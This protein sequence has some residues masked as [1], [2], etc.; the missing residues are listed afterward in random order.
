ME[1]NLVYEFF[2][3]ILGDHGLGWV[4]KIISFVIVTFLTAVINRITTYFIDFLKKARE[5]RK[6]SKKLQDLN[7]FFSNTDISIHRKFF[8]ETKGQNLPPS[9]ELEPIRIE[10]LVFKE[11]LID[12]LLNQYLLVK[13]IKDKYFLVLAGSGMGKT[14]FMIN[15]FLRY[16]EKKVKNKLKIKLIPLGYP[17]VWS[18]IKKIIEDQEDQ[19]TILLLDAFDED[20]KAVINYQLRFEELINLTKNFHAVIISCRTQFFPNERSLPSELMVPKLDLQNPGFHN[21]QIFYISPF[22]ETDIKQYLK[23]K[24]PK[25]KKLRL[26]AKKIV[27]QFPHLAVRP[28]LLS[29]IEDLVEDKK[30]KFQYSYQIYDLLVKKWIDRE[31]GRKPKLKRE[32]YR[33]ELSRFSVQFARK[34]YLG[35]KERNQALSVPRSELLQFA[36]DHNV[37]LDDIDVTSRS[38]L[39]RD[40]DGN[41]KFSHKSIF[42]YLLSK[43]MLKDTSLLYQAKFDGLDMTE[44]FL[45]E[46]GI[47]PEVIHVEG[48]KF[49]MGSDKNDEEMPVHLVEVK[50]FWI[51]KFPV[52]NKEWKRVL[53][54]NEDFEKNPEEPVVNIS[55]KDIKEFLEKLNE[56]TGL[57]YRLLTEAEWEFAANGGVRSE[58]FR[59][60]G[61]N[62]IDKVAWCST[63]T[64]SIQIVG[65]KKPNILGIFDMSGNVWEFCEDSW[66][67][68][69]QNAPNDGS[70]WKNTRIST[71]VIRGG[72]WDSEKDFCS[73]TCRLEG[74]SPSQS[75][76]FRIVRSLCEK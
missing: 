15:L 2:S 4:G 50:S 16:H 74:G 26:L 27:L 7:P 57:D 29:R 41:Y 71:N 70:A 35:Q 49:F 30:I 73:I 51:G 54:L 6:D 22:D 75:I 9:N 19:E 34:I 60:S 45:N 66:H 37:N 36:N 69:Y 12:K 67:E 72:A 43:E 39:N 65:Q 14:T 42:E 28:M 68:N 52:K 61:S 24:F 62:K 63:N 21:I 3:N 38:L 58:G 10:S 31:A 48:G 20:G 46:M 47:I 53:E 76:G 59:Y 44:K 25:N 1:S 40:G 33:S 56:K 5:K 17:E 11:P 55:F 18:Q 13:D 23:K 32:L 8:I 64:D